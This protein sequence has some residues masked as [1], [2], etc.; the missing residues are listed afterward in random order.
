MSGLENRN[1]VTERKKYSVVVD[2][3][4]FSIVILIF[5]KPGIADDIPIIDFIFNAGRVGLSI[6]YIGR[7][8]INKKRINKD[9]L[10][11]CVISVIVLTSTFLVGKAYPKAL[12]HYFPSLGMLAFISLNSRKIDRLLVLVENLGIVLLTANLITVLL[13]PGGLLY[14]EAN[15]LKIWILGQKQD[16][17][18]FIFPFLYVALCLKHFD[19]KFSSKYWMILIISCVSAIL[20]QPLGTLICL[21]LFLFLCF[22]DQYILKFEKRLLISILICGFI[23]TQY[24]CFN[25]EEMIWL[26][27]IL[28]GINLKGASKLRTVNIRIE[29]WR[30]AWDTIAKYPLIGVGNLTV[31]NWSLMTKIGYHSILDNMYMDMLFTG[32]LVSFFIFILLIGRSFKMIRELWKCRTGRQMGYCL[33]ALCILLLEGCPYYPSVF[34]MLVSSVWFP[35]L[36]EGRVCDRDGDKK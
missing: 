17:G 16:I 25:F 5:L 2:D 23:I 14:R 1:Y 27:K 26:Q 29:M 4:W 24:I 7:M 36:M 32:G 10:L 15:N 18:G 12:T 3:I 8:L 28:S 20:E 30:F 9:W 31:R 35:Y 21:S 34:F 22:W 33:F 6:V 19:K 13:F 11:L